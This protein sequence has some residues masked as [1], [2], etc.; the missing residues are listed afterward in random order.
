MN[1]NEIVRGFDDKRDE[2]LTIQ[3]RGFDAIKDYLRP[4]IIYCVNP[5]A[6]R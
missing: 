5:K 6:A 3:I 1:N 2:N 4:W